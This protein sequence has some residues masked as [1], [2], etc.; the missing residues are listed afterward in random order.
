MAR[1]KRVWVTLCAATAV[2]FALAPAGPPAFAAGDPAAKAEAIAAFQRL[3]A[4]PTFRVKWTNPEANGLLEFVQP[5]QQHLTAKSDKGSIEIFQ[6]GTETR[7]HYDY[8]GAPSGWRCFNGQQG[9]PRWFNVDKMREDT[10]TEV[11]RRPD[12]VINGTPVHAYTDTKTRG[13]LYVGIQN[14]LPRRFVGF[15]PKGNFT[16]DFYDFGVPIMLTPPACG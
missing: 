12:T 9:I 1:V 15:E 2:G 3:F 10:T 8:P 16:G 11:V 7:M 5:N 13:E 4:L 14:G 6:I